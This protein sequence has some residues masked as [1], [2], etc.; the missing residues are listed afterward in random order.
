MGEGTTSCEEGEHISW[1]KSRRPVY[2][3][4]GFPKGG[5]KPLFKLA[6]ELEAMEAT[7]LRSNI[8]VDG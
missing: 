4:A 8:H 6:L 7:H 2:R 3:A 5:P 1:I